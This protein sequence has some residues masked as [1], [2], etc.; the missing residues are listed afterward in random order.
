MIIIIIHRIFS[1]PLI[2]N[3]YI[4]SCL[5]PEMVI[6]YVFAENVLRPFNI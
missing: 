3:M 6:M 4:Q 1:V 2:C 5:A